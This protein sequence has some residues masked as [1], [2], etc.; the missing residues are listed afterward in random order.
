MWTKKTANTETNIFGDSEMEIS[1][2]DFYSRIVVLKNMF[3]EV[4]WKHKNFSGYFETLLAQLQDV[5]KL[6]LLIGLSRWL[7]NQEKTFDEEL[8]SLYNE[9]RILEVLA[10]SL[11]DFQ[12]R[13]MFGEIA[14][15]HKVREAFVTQ[16]F[17]KI[18]EVNVPVS[19]VHQE[20]HHVNHVDMIYVCAIARTTDANRLFEF[21]TYRGQTTCGLAS[22]CPDAQVYT[23]NLPPEEDPRYAPY[24][25][26]FISESPHKN[27]IEQIYCDSRKFDV[28]P[29]VGMMDYIFIDG[30]HSYEGVKNDTEKALAMLKPGGIIVWHDYAS[31][32]P[33][34]LKYLS[35]LSAERPIFHVKKTCLALYVDGLDEG[36]I[37]LT[38]LESSLE[39]DEYGND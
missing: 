31:K 20:S 28:A 13:V 16:L 17:P 39:E 32:S 27:R 29:Y 14:R 2:K 30:D 4:I 19:V 35:E 15:N 7:K 3:E 38:P 33:G 8:S 26:K 9:G 22:V 12:G 24:I 10:A 37:E 1:K 23:L 21:G 25:G 34:V 11:S 5:S 6:S 36:K 18:S